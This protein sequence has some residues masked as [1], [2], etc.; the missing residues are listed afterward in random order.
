MATNKGDIRVTRRG[1]Q[2]AL[3]GLWFLDGLLQLQHQMFTSAFATQVIAPSAA[4]QPRIIS[5]VMHYWISLF[6]SHPAIC[7][8]VIVL[9]QLSIGLLLFNKRTVRVGLLCRK[10]LWGIFVWYVGEGLGG[11][12]TGETSM[13][14]GAPGAA[15]IYSVLSLAA[16][17]SDDDEQ[18]KAEH[19]Y[20]SAWLPFLW[21]FLW[22]GAAIYQL[23]PS[24]NSVNSL[25][26]HDRWWYA[27][28]TRLHWLL[29]TRYPSSGISGFA[30]SGSPG[31][32]YWFILL[33]AVLQ[34]GIGVSVFAQKTSR[35]F[36]IQIGIVL[37]VIFWVVG[38]NL[39]SYWTGLAT[40]LNTAPLVILLGLAILGNQ[41][42]DTGL[43]KIYK[44]LEGVFI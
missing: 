8:W 20:P 40:D 29:S 7:N 42:L 38:Q 39:G 11:V 28:R 15:L 33:L 23:L 44:K 35:E 19:H 24:Q 9:V 16:I 31:S 43:K 4:E 6:L 34:L 10:L 21:A 32:G 3:G 14:M 37:S 36:A 5:G 22:I 1:L 12:F 17:P 30:T 13:L 26:R 27:W 25:I 18:P 2:L 41:T